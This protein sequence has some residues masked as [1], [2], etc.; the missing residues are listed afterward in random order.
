MSPLSWKA[1]ENLFHGVNLILTFPQAGW[2]YL[3]P[4]PCACSFLAQS[5]FLIAASARL[6]AEAKESPSPGL[7]PPRRSAQRQHPMGPAGSA[8]LLPPGAFWLRL[9]S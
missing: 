6:P 3:L 2:G 4:G 9:L 7:G 8:P 1:R 5:D